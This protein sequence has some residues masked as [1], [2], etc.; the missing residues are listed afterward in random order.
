M[1]PYKCLHMIMELGLENWEDNK[2]KSLQDVCWVRRV[3][4]EDDVVGN[5]ISEDFIGDVR[6]MPIHMEKTRLPICKFLG[7]II[8]EL[9]EL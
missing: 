6:V 8:K 5:G 7:S 3:A 4:K 9:E 1:L 2:I